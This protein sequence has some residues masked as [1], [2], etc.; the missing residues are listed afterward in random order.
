MPGTVFNLGT[1]QDVNP[2]HRCC[3]ERHGI[4][5]ASRIP[6]TVLNGGG[7]RHCISHSL[8][9][10]LMKDSWAFTGLFFYRL[11]V[12]KW[13]RPFSCSYELVAQDLRG[14]RPTCC[15]QRWL[16]WRMKSWRVEILEM[17]VQ[18]LFQGTPHQEHQGSSCCSCNRSLYSWRLVK[19]QDA[20]LSS[21]KGLMVLPCRPRR[22]SGMGLTFTQVALLTYTPPDPRHC[23]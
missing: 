15:S 21:W 13:R 11:S 22:V 9:K 7:R 18:S 16:Q 8:S 23:H 19:P 12:R 20:N 5:L 2:A 17:V 4:K 3:P 14:Q 1:W 10:H 6:L